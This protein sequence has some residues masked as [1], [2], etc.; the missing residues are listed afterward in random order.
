MDNKKE[1][2]LS[3][4]EKLSNLDFQKDVWQDQKYWDAIL[5]YGEAVNTLEDYGFFDDVETGKIVLQNEQ[6]Q[7]KLISFIDCL[8]NYEEPLNTEIMIS[9]TNWLSIVNKA[10]EIKVLLL[11]IDFKN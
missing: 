11:D 8:L 5:N 2:V 6:E 7:K 4:L 1:I 9:D 10:S 3:I